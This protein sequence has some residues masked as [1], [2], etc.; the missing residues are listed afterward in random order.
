MFRVSSPL[1]NYTSL[2]WKESFSILNTTRGHLMAN[3]SSQK[4]KFFV[5]VILIYHISGGAL[6]RGYDRVN[7]GLGL[8]AQRLPLSNYSRTRRRSHN[9]ALKF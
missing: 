9:V 5:G 8:A 1:I 6:W 3:E 2:D 7:T 4:P